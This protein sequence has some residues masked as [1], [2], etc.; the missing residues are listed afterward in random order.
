MQKY[1][2][3]PGVIRY[4][5][6]NN[7]AGSESSNPAETFKQITK[8]VSFNAHGFLTYF[9]CFLIF[10]VFDFFVTLK[11]HFRNL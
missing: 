2:R 7:L 3:R 5:V 9:L 8:A 11:F 6:K 10:G 1:N 4:K